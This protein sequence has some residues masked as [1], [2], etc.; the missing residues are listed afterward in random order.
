MMILIDT[1][2]WV[3]LLSREPNHKIPA[4]KLPVLATCPPVI[5]EVLQGIRDHDAHREISAG[6]NALTIFGSPMPLELYESAAQIYREGRRQGFTVKSYI[7]CLVAAI[8]LQ[9]NLLIWHMDRDYDLIAK[10]RPLKV[11]KEI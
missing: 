7:D 2:I 8:A 9:H 3:D 5:Q 1:S 11:T 10:F 4:E 6:L